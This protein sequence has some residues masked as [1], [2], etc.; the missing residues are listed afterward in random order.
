MLLIVFDEYGVS[1]Y[2]FTLTQRSGGWIGKSG[3]CLNCRMLAFFMSSCITKTIFYSNFFFGIEKYMFEKY[4]NTEQKPLI[5]DNLMY[6]VFIQNI[7]EDV[8]NFSKLC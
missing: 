6:F 4:G 2:L 1:S 7:C 5:I 8:Y 3:Q